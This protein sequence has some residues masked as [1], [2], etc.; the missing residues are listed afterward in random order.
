MIWPSR[1]QPHISFGHDFDES[2]GFM[3]QPELLKGGFIGLLSLSRICEIQ[4]IKN[5]L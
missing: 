3:N 1:Q 4:E 5:P 2:D